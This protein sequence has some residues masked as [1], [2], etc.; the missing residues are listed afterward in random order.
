MK[1]ST[2]SRWLLAAL[3]LAGLAGWAVTGLFLYARLAYL[4]LFLFIGAGAWAILSMRGVRLKR[5]ARSLRASMG[6]VFEEEFEVEK[7]AWPA[8]AWI[9]VD[10]R[11]NLPLAAGSRVLT[12]IGSHQR[13]FYSA[14]TLLVRRGAFQ[15]GPTT[16]RTGDPFGLFSIDKHQP[17]AETLIILPMA[18]PIITFPPPPGLLPGGKATRQHS[19]DVTPHAAGVREYVPGD[20]MKRIHWA[21]TARRGRFMVKEFEQD[22]QADIWLFLDAEEGVH[23]SMPEE[24]I[25]YQQDGW[26]LRHPQIGL[27]RNSFEYAVSMTASLASFFLTDRRAVGLA[28]AVGKLAVVPADRG[29]RQMSK[30]METLAFLQPEGSLPLSGLV[31]LQAKLL[32]IGSGVI[33]VTPSIRPDLLLAVEDLKRRN[34]RPVVVLIKAETFGGTPGTEQLAAGLINHNVPVCQVGFGDDLSVK[35]ALPAVYFQQFRLSKAYHS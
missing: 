14:R 19:L 20:P 17:A 15:L 10:N 8:C 22:P 27:P 32:P 35:L 12:R 30:I 34:L 25:S 26:W 4:G 24:E 2:A 9:E 13:R 31:A 7:G 1:P 33:L 11:S 6:D 5:M 21:S 23:A 29:E 3:V 16:L 28:S 18:F